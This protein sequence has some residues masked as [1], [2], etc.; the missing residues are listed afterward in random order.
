MSFSTLVRS[1]RSFRPWNV[2]LA[3]VATTTT[4]LAFATSLDEDTNAS[5]HHQQ[6]QQP[7]VDTFLEPDFMDRIRRKPYMKE[8]RERGFLP[9]HLRI[10]T[11]DV[12][13]LRHHL[14]GACGI[15]YKASFEDGVAPDRILS[16]GRRITQAT[17]A[18]SVYRCKTSST[19]GLEV[20]ET[21][22]RPL[23]PNNVRRNAP[24]VNAVEKMKQSIQTT[25]SNQTS[26]NQ[27]KKTTIPIEVE[28]PV[29]ATEQDE[30][31]APWNQYAWPD[32]LVLRVSH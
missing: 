12:P 31:T 8:Q 20:L 27:Q 6:Q 2:A 16:D 14:Q 24:V 7:P 21:S 10:M 1:L 30:V 28:E 15:N 19:I 9:T 5:Q 17:L 18:Q 23:N 25:K 3:G 4:A 29:P 26:T 32:E 22:V 11:I 13:E